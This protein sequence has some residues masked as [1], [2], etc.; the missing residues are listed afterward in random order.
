MKTMKLSAFVLIILASVLGCQ[1]DPEEVILNKIPIADAG[2]SDTITLPI[3]SFMLSGS[4]S[5]VDGNVVAYVWS[6]VSGPDA[7][8][9]VNPGSPTTFV[10]GFVEGT[11]L[12]QLLVTD[13]DGA[14]GID[15]VSLKVLPPE[16]QTLVLQPANNPT[17]RSLVELNGIDQSSSSGI[18]LPVEAWTIN[19]NPVKI[20]SLLKFNLSAIPQNATIISAQLELYSYPSPTNNGNFTDANFGTSNSLI[21]QQVSTNWNPATTT[22]TNQPAGLTQNQLLIPHT[23]S[24]ILDLNLNV[25]GMVSSMIKTNANYGFLLRLQDEVIYNSRIFV[26]SNNTL[27]PTKRPKLTIVYQ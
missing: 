7:T 14:T 2:L 6:Q 15:T 3:K 25:K 19:G 1:P 22:W 24:N 23:T 8:T 26:S 18:D 5:D 13:D 20:R 16:T 4:G 9:I 21:L 12:F 10:E 17:E 11:Y 27:Y